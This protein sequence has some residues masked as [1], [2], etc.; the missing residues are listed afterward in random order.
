MMYPRWLSSRLAV[1][2]ENNWRLLSVSSRC[3][4]RSAVRESCPVKLYAIAM[5][6]SK[7]PAPATNPAVI[8]RSRV[9]GTAPNIRASASNPPPNN[10][11]A[12]EVCTAMPV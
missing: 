2:V 12:V 1:S 6:A 8:Q 10:A 7:S 9:H 3:A 11:N 4:T 5:E